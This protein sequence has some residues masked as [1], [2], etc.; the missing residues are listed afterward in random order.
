M[1]RLS[2]HG[3]VKAVLPPGLLGTPDMKTKMRLRALDSSHVIGWIR[4]KW[5]SG[6]NNDHESPLL[7]L[8]EPYLEGS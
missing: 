2:G 3:E 4:K 7:A 8:S 6:I 1:T 5:F